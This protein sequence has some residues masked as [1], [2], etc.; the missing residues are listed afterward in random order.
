MSSAK[1]HLK[2]RVIES[3]VV[4]IFQQTWCE[5][6]CCRNAVKA[7]EKNGKLPKRFLL[8]VNG[9]YSNQK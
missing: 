3:D 7:F 5:D 4:D 2:S 8:I 1:A 6:S 9:L